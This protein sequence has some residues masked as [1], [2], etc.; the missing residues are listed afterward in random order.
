VPHRILIR[1]SAAKPDARLLY[2]NAQM[3]PISDANRPDPLAE[4][5]SP[6]KYLAIAGIIA[7]AIPLI[8][9][10]LNLGDA[11]IRPFALVLGKPTTALVSSKRISH[12]RHSSGNYLELNYEYSPD[13]APRP[14]IKVN[15]AAYAAIVLNTHVPIHYI[16]GC[17]SCI[18]L[19][20]DY[21]SA[22]H[23]GLEGLAMV[24]FV[25]G[26]TYL[27]YRFKKKT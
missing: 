19:D 1:S 12:G 20:D 4:P 14:D 11:L 22:R 7:I 24:L 6:L 26:L 27:Q 9:F 17:S 16:R 23:Q 2:D 13:F 3:D 25:F 5:S 8:A 15:D 18:A 21:G 10:Y